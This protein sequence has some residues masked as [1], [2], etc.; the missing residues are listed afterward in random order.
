MKTESENESESDRKTSNWVN[1]KREQFQAKPIWLTGMLA[2]NG[3][4]WAESLWKRK[5]IASLKF[6]FKFR[7]PARV[8]RKNKWDKDTQITLKG[9]AERM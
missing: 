7:S 3:N 8:M 2:D 1:N 4:Q 5:Q 9:E 6:V